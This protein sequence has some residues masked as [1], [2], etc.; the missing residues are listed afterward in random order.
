[1]D[2]L[3]KHWDEVQATNTFQEKLEEVASADYSNRGKII[4]EIFRRVSMRVA[5]DQN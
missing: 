3:I 1:M 2:F 4:A 5:R